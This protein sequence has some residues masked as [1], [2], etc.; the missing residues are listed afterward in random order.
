MELATGAGALVAVAAVNRRQPKTNHGYDSA[1][2][3]FHI[4]IVVRDRLIHN[5]LLE[6]NDSQAASA[7][8]STV[9]FGL[10]NRLT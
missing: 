10:R 1:A 9:T 8:G 5:L 7:N 6:E 3:G 4:P 2:S